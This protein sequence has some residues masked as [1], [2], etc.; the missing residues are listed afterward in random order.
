MFIISL[1]SSLLSKQRTRNLPA[2]SS[3]TPVPYAHSL[4]HIESISV[5]S[6]ED[7]LVNHARSKG[8][9]LHFQVVG[10]VTFRDAILSFLRNHPNV[11]LSTR[12]LNIITNK[13]MVTIMSNAKLNHPST[14]AVVPTPLRT[15]PFPKSCAIIDAA[16][17]AVCCHK[18]DTR[19]K[20]EEIK[21]MAR[22]IWETGREGKGLTSRSE[23]SRSSSCQPGKVA[24]RS[25]QMNAKMM[26]MMLEVC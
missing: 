9:K 15:L 21:M 4:I 19:T 10:V 23:P 6:I 25:R 8:I 1:I 20:I 13:P 26:A 17:D 22:A 14:M 2:N 3:Q 5:D 24:K 11:S 7:L 12:I 18:T 16:T